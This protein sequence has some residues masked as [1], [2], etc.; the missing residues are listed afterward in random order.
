MSVASEGWPFVA[1]SG[2][3]STLAATLAL[4]GVGPAWAVAAPGLVLTLWIVW[5][6]RDPVREGPRGPELIIA[7]ADGRVL[8]TTTVDEPFFECGRAQRV[9]IFMNVFDVHVNRHPVTGTV[10]AYAY[11]PGAFINASFDKASTLNERASLGIHTEQGRVV[12]RQIA[13]LVARRI[14]TDP[15]EGESV[16]QGER[17]GLI[18]FGSRVDIFLP[19]DVEITVREGD[20]TRAGETVIGRWPTT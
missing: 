10:G 12:V 20:R 18:R 5:F 6:F 14:V 3:V 13:G 2:T 17:L 19:L 11:H 9:S 16:A 8:P 15:R 4:S 7:P 1:V